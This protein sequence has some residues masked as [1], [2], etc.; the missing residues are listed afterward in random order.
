MLSLKQITSMGIV[1]LWILT[2][3]VTRAADGNRTITGH[4]YCILPTSEGIKL[5]PGACPGGENHGA[6]FIKTQDGKLILLQESPILADLPKLSAEEK[7]NVTMEGENISP[8]VFN[9]EV[10]KWPWLNK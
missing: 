9:P 3:T 4:V 8:T 6:H 7:K 1:V 5:E 2:A 10:V